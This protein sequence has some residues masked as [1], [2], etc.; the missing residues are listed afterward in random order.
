MNINNKLNSYLVQNKELYGNQ[1]FRKTKNISGKN[2]YQISSFDQNKS[3]QDYNISI[4]L[5]QK[6]NL[7]KTRKNFV[8]GEGDSN[9]DLMLVGEAPGEI[10]DLK[11]K[12]FIG[13]AGK[14][15]DNILKAINRNRTEGVYIANI[16]KCRP[17]DN[18]DPLQSE[19]KEC[20]PY[21]INQI[22]IINP[23]LIVALGKIAAKNLIQQ[24]AA[25]EKM[26]NKTHN[27]NG[28]PLRITYHP[29]AL[30]RN[31]DLKKDTW[32]DFKWIRDYLN[33]DA[34]RS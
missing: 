5:C 34:K 23:K 4:C 16:V 1:L 2:N 8:F 11:G 14:L 24:D 32:E 19:V 30:L 27:Y 33:K 7:A 25:L 22:K 18:R 10:E 13:K 28:I 31:P 15:L 21:L 20:E 29:A 12:P 9:A 17:P 3:L 26:R 6:C